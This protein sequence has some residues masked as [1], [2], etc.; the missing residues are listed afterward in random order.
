MTEELRIIS[1]K[2]IKASDLVDLLKVRYQAPEWACLTQV[3]NGT[4]ASGGRYADV[5]AMNLWPSRGLEIVG[6]EIKV[7]RS[8]WVSELRN[9]KK[10]DDMM[11][12]CDSWILCV[13]DAAI[14]QPGEL[15]KGWG[16]LA[17]L[18]EKKDKLKCHVEA[19]RKVADLT[20]P[21]MA[22]LIRRVSEQLTSE[23]KM[24]AVRVAAFDKGK[25]DGKESAKHE[26]E[27]ACRDHK[28][29]QK[30]VADFQN[31]SGVRINTYRGGNIG[32]AV[33]A[34]QN[35]GLLRVIADMEIMQST[36]VKLSELITDQLKEIRKP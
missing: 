14:V 1:P 18:G 21:F 27:W 11:K 34:V 15:P 20:K 17:P 29:L 31:A 23:A 6:V 24:E 28:Q 22:A 7:S 5:V 3:A 10:A 36:A 32:D 12:H 8:D 9:P 2:P 30:D 19:E 25:A 35:G 33:R 13:S 16:L 4:G 26:M